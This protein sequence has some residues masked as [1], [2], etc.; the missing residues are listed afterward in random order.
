MLYAYDTVNIFKRLQQKNFLFQSYQ[1]IASCPR[2]LTPL[3]IMLKNDQT[4]FKNL[5]MLTR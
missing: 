2:N 3:W 1:K 4:Y 5:A